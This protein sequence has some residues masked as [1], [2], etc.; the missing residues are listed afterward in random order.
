MKAKSLYQRKGKPS[1]PSSR[2]N[3]GRVESRDRILSKDELIDLL[4][5][6][7][8]DCV[9]S[10]ERAINESLPVLLFLEKALDQDEPMEPLVL[11]MKD[12]DINYC[13]SGNAVGYILRGLTAQLHEGWNKIDESHMGAW[14]EAQRCR[15]GR[16]KAAK[17]R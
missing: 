5:R 16:P 15:K 7:V 10:A 14:G 3:T 8:E 12:R 2:E 6:T 1:N 9:A 13:H 4:D 17:S 11:H